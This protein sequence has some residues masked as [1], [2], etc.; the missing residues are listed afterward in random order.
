[1]LTE[2][3]LEGSNPLLRGGLL[4]QTRR[5]Q[6]LIQGGLA[7]SLPSYQSKNCLSQIPLPRSW[8]QFY[9]LMLPE[10]FFW[11]I[12]SLT[13]GR[14]ASSSNKKDPT[15]YPGGLASSL[16]QLS[17]QKLR[18]ST[19]NYTLADCSS[20]SSSDF[21]TTKFIYQLSLISSQTSRNSAKFTN[22][23]KLQQNLRQGNNRSYLT[24]CHLRYLLLNAQK[25]FKFLPAKLQYLVL[26][27]GCWILQPCQQSLAGRSKTQA[28]FL[29]LEQWADPRGHD[30]CLKIITN[31]F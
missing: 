16:V 29:F 1:M 5:I 18:K 7:S 22:Y 28:K 15:P 8:P 30:S 26:S 19:L 13:Q 12:Q 14:L 24:T 23:T 31:Y 9:F 2:K 20:I 27:N 6:P 25:T 3:F 21:L 4:L 17:K 10:K 11:R